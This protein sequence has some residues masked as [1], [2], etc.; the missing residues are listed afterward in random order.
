MRPI[1]AKRDFRGRTT[2]IN[3]LDT[4]FL[5]GCKVVQPDPG[6][7]DAYATQAAQRRGRRP[8]SSEIGSAMLERNSMSGPASNGSL[9][10][11]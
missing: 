4:L 6:R 3:R 5:E 1:L 8:T 9:S 11:E 10:Q 2:M 7:L